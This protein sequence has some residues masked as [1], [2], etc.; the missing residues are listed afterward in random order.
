M[1]KLFHGKEQFL[2]LREAKG[3]LEQLR[4]E[5]PEFEIVVVEAHDKSPESIIS[6]VTTNPLFSTS[7]IIFLKRL[8]SNKRKEDLVSF[9]I[10]SFDTLENSYHFVFWEDHKIASNTKFF[11]AFKKNIQESVLMNKPNFYKWAAEQLE[12]AGIKSDRA[13]LMLLCQRVNYSPERLINEVD[14]Y[15]ILEIKTLTKEI[16]TENTTD[17]YEQDIWDLTDAINQDNKVEVFS[18]LERLYN[19]QVDPNFIIAMMARNLRLL[20]QVK[21]L[22][23]KN[24]DFK[25]I[26]SVLRIPPFTLPQLSLSAKK[27]EWGKMKYL[28][29]KMASLDF[30]IKRGNIEPQTGLTLLLNRI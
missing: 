15:E 20:T 27:S 5:N 25:T 3:F 24:T 8:F 18:T 7:K 19:Q 28:Y 13:T 2:S 14:K 1:K 10:S 16:I 6:I 29:E 26:S 22:L 12:K 30:E 11:K 4:Q 21:T 23:D 17:T 9:L